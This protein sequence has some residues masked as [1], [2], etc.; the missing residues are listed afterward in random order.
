MDFID[1]LI[2][3]DRDC[4]CLYLSSFAVVSTLDASLCFSPVG[5][6]LRINFSLRLIKYPSIHPSMLIAVAK[7]S[8]KQCAYFTTRCR[9][10]APHANC[11]KPAPA[12]LER[13]PAP[14][15]LTLPQ[16]KTL[17]DSAKWQREHA[18]LR[19]RGRLSRYLIHQQPL[20]L[21]LWARICSTSCRLLACSSWVGAGLE[22]GKESRE[23]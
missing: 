17:N 18:G 12:V 15:P 4:D 1:L 8:K 14:R 22:A 21:L 16:N 7:L 13:L 11:H 6:L 10:F 19:T 5:F 20:Q 3:F 9:S 2:W 23:Y